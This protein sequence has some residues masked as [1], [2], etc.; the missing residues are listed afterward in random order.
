MLSP[1]CRD[2]G[3]KSHAALIS[4]AVGAATRD[5]RPGPARDA[6][7][8]PGRPA[9]TLRSEDLSAAD[10]ATRNRLIG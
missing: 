5:G 7:L 10:A 1:R 2:A 8:T 9:S 4:R 6:V 3:T